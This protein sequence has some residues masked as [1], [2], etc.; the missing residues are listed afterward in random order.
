MMEL[1]NTR[2]EMFSNWSLPSM[3]LF[4]DEAKAW[5]FPEQASTYAAES[6]ATYRMIAWIC[7]VFFLTV[8]I[9]LAY[10]VYN[11][12]KA[13]GEKATSRIRHHNLLEISWS[14]IPC[15]FLVVMFVRGTWG[16]LDMQNAPEGAVQVDLEAYKWG[17]A[18]NYGGGAIHP[19]LHVVKGQPTK[20]VMRSSDVLHAFYVP[21]FRIKRDIVPGR[22]SLVWFEPTVSSTKVSDTELEEAKRIQEEEEQPIWDYDR[23]QFTEDGYTYYD[24][25]C[26]EYCGRDHSAMQAYVVV[27][28]SQESLDDWLRKISSRG[29][30]DPA[31]YG[32]KLY[33]LRNCIGCH[34][35]EPDKV[36]VGPSFHN[37]YGYEREMIDGLVVMGD[38]EYIRESILYPN[39]KIV[40]G[41]RAQMPSFQ[42]QLS[43]DDIDSLIAYMR[44]LSD[45]GQTLADGAENLESESPS[46]PEAGSED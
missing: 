41:F 38:E 21:A 37:L 28:E 29:D 13:K 20:V 12:S 23:W 35:A 31:E 9:P 1:V 10:F 11:Y 22:Y 6:D 18:F 4:G 43:D 24:L 45:R 25:F 3:A 33:R 34:S 40:K 32:E 46:D 16:Y 17:F 42:G 39:A 44:T 30:Q 26:A 5:W 15:V 7:V 2:S 14:V 27:H 8:M 19:E 36:V